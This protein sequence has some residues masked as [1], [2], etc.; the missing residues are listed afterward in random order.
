MPRGREYPRCHFWV[1]LPEPGVLPSFE[2]I[3]RPARTFFLREPRGGRRV[4]RLTMDFF[5]SFFFAIT[6][7]TTSTRW[8]TLWIMPRVSGVSW[9]STTCCKR[10]KPRPRIV[11]RIS[12]VQLIKLTTHLILTVPEDAVFF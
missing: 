12:S 7:F 10:R 6:Y 2:P 5:S 1:W 4:E 8:R 3:P 9:R 11:C